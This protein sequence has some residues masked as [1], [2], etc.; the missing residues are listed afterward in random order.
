MDFEP[1]LSRIRSK[2]AEAARRDPDCKVFGADIHRYR[3]HPPTTPQRVSEFEALHGI[4]LPEP[5]VAFLTGIGHGGPGHFGAAGPYYGVYALG[6]FGFMPTTPESLSAPCRITS[7][8]TEEDWI[9]MTD[10]DDALDPDSAEYGRRYDA[11]FDGLMSIGTR[12]CNAQTM[13]ALNG[14]DRGRI[15]AIDQDLNRPSVDREAHF[16]DW[17]EAWLDRSSKNP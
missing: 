15:V 10:F 14:P 3:M 8:L 6:Q 7:A 11:L 16:L 5:Y 13:L 12:G 4:R 2:L 1:Q 17:Y 9:R